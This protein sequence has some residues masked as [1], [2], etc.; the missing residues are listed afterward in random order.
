MPCGMEAL[1]K[2]SCARMRSTVCND[3]G[4]R[5]AE[6][7]DRHGALAVQIAGGADVLHG[8]DH[9]GHVRQAD[10]RAVVVADDERLVVV[11]VGDLVVGEDVRGQMPSVIW[12]LARSEFCR[13]S[14]DC[15]FASVSP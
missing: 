7:D 12:P 9:V 10:G 2:G 11:R 3:V 5:L 13:L 15:K 6:D 1:I 14:T 4:A 8:V